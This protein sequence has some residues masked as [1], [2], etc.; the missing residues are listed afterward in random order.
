MPGGLT[1][2][3][4]VVSFSKIVSSG[5]LSVNKRKTND[6]L[7]YFLKK[8]HIVYL[9]TELNIYFQNLSNVSNKSMFIKVGHTHC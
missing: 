1:D 7:N 4:D 3:F 6:I 5:W 2:L 8:E 9:H